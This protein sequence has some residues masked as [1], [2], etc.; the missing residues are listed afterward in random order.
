MAEKALAGFERIELA[1]GESKQVQIHVGERELSYWSV[2]KHDWVVPSTFRPIYVG[3]SSRDIR[4][5]KVVHD[6][7]G[8]RPP[9]S[10]ETPNQAKAGQTVP[11][12]FSLNGD[13]GLSAVVEGYPLYQPLTCDS[14]EPEGDAVPAFSVAGLQYDPAADQYIFT[15]KT[16]K[17]WA[18]SYGR[19]D[20][21]LNDGTV[22]SAIFLFK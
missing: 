11:V 7:S 6:W 12:K 20:F 15:W 10:G 1:P 8:F 21:L 13:Y 17:Q 5:E 4:L 22:H 18:G 3:A 9:V 16:E 19:I 14:N 2:E